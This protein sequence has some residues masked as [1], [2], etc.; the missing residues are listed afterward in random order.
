VNQGTLLT[1][2]GIVILVFATGSLPPNTDIS[3]SLS[4]GDYVPT[5]NAL[6]S[7]IPPAGFS[8]GFNRKCVFG[9]ET[10]SFED[11]FKIEYDTNNLPGSLNYN[12]VADTTGFGDF[13]AFCMVEYYDCRLF[14][15]NCLSCISHS[16]CTSCTPDYYVQA[17][18]NTT[19]VCLLCANAFWACHYCTVPTVCHACFTPTHLKNLTDDTCVFCRAY[20]SNCERCT[21]TLT[22]TLCDPYYGISGG[23]C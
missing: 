19:A 18:P 22:C 1:S 14:D 9:F 15:L 17:Y 10:Y 5:I 6:Y 21:D 12:I 7:T 8:T 11:N 16:I 3:Y 13:T 2:A 23:V 4:I 20:L